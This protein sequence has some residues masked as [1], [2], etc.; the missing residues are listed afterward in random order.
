MKLRDVSNISKISEWEEV[1]PCYT[2]NPSDYRAYT[3]KACC[4]PGPVKTA[5]FHWENTVETALPKPIKSL[6]NAIY[7]STQE[8]DKIYVVAQMVKR[9]PTIQ[10]TWVQSLGW[11]DPLEKEMATHPSTLAWRIPWTEE[12]GRLQ[13]LGSQRVGRDWATERHITSHV[14]HMSVHNPES[15][16]QSFLVKYQV[17]SM[18]LNVWKKYLFTDAIWVEY[19][20]P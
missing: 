15:K 19:S 10:E 13:S 16:T 17:G 8:I 1:K 7:S 6:K 2:P 14:L 12:P 18:I 4:L 20:F 11:E 3:A 5:W 9:L